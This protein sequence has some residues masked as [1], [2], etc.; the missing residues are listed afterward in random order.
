M[1]QEPHETLE[2][3]RVPTKEEKKVKRILTN[4]NFVLMSSF[5]RVV[6]CCIDNTRITIKKPDIY[7]VHHADTCIYFGVP[8]AQEPVQQA[9]EHTTTELGL[10]HGYLVEL[11]SD[12]SGQEVRLST[13]CLLYTSTI[14]L[15][16]NE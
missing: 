3:L 9:Q 6:M 11:R 14:Y 10:L 5:N 8:C 4:L 12:L 13:V 2:S 16:T 15:F 7:R 1:S